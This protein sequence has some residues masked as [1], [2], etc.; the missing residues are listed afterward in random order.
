MRT[1]VNEFVRSCPACQLNKKKRKAPR[2]YQKFPTTSRFQTVHI[3]LVGPLRTSR[4]SNKYLL[5]I[6]DR[7]SRWLEAIPISNMEAETVS[8]EFFRCWIARAGIPNVIVTDQGSQFES[9]IFNDLLERF[10]I[11]RRRTTTYHPQSNGLIE[12]SH[13][14]IKNI[15]RC[16]AEK[17]SRWGV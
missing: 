11:K 4:Q 7:F 3:D 16:I 17:S 1:Q 10:G 8:C 13:S 6:M 14:T 5:T 9:K 2:T 12:R 15:L